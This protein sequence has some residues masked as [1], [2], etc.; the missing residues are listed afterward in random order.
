MNL[1]ILILGIANL[2]LAFFVPPIAV[3]INGFSAGWCLCY[4]TIWICETLRRPQ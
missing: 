4:S 1:A 3:V 2:T